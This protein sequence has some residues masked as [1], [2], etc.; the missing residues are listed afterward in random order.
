MNLQIF[1]NALVNAAL[2]AP[3]AMAFSL[4]F[5]VLKFPN[6]AIGGYITVGAFAAY[7][8]NVP[9]GWSLPLATLGA[10][11]VTGFVVW[12]A[13]VLVFKPMQAQS[14]VTLL[15]VSIALTLILESVVRLFFSADVRGFDIPLERPWKLWGARITRE[16]VEIIVCAVILGTGLHVLLRH[17]RLGRAMRAVADNPML[18]AIRGVDAAKITAL[19]TVLCGAIFGLTGVF[20]GLDLVIEPLVGWNLTIPIFAAAIL[21]GIGSPY[22][23]ILGALMLGLAEELTI[24]VL[25]S[26]YKI[27]VGFVIIAVFLLVR[28]QGLF[29]TA[30]IKK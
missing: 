9:M 12:L 2:I 1:V 19:T 16:Q 23:A 22:G 24:L 6:F 18:A 3:P 15:V 14:A 8:F 20:A 30:E 25:P 4:L 13:H 10:M 29:G 17:T 28:P 11:A 26:T 7:T 5:G 27:A 21:G